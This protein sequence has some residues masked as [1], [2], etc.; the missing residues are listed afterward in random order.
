MKKVKIMFCFFKI[1]MP[2]SSSSTLYCVF[3]TDIKFIDKY[4]YY[5]TT[6]KVNNSNTDYKVQEEF[7]RVKFTLVYF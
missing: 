1:K 5:T 4:C 3:N 6:I 7:R 2:L